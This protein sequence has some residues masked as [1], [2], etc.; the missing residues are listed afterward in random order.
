MNEAF[1]KII[2]YR[3]AKMNLIRIEAFM[4][5]DNVPSLKM[6]QKFGFTKKCQLREHYFKNNAIKDSI[7]FSLLRK[8]NYKTYRRLFVKR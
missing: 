7:V 5:P 6:V 3:F 8:D 2:E 1:E 4:G